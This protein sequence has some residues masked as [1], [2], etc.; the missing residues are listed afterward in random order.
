MEIAGVDPGRDLA[1]LRIKPAKDLPTLR[2]GDS[3]QMSAGDQVIAIG[4][5]LGVF[6][7]SCR[8]A[9]SARSAPCAARPRRSARPVA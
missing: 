5:P 7:Y 9:S 3:D 8:V 4:N 6:D 1:V 2:L